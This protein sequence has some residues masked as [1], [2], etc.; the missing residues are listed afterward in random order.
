MVLNLT[1]EIMHKY[2]QDRSTQCWR[3]CGK[4]GTMVHIFIKCWKGINTPKKWLQVS[5]PNIKEWLERVDYICKM[6][7]LSSRDE[8]QVE[9]YNGIWAKWSAFRLTTRYVEWVK[10]EVSDI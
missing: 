4:I 9:I 5:K 1:P 3:D 10:E 8:G 2:H 7:Y 6:E